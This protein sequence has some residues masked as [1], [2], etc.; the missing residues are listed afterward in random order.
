MIIC[1]FNQACLYFYANTHGNPH[2]K[3]VWN[4]YVE[5]LSGFCSIQLIQEK[6]IDF[7]FKVLQALVGTRLCVLDL[8]E[9]QLCHLNY[10]TMNSLEQVCYKE[11]S[12]N[13]AKY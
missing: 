3:R 13:G 6:N 2:S 4:L 12:H 10:T 8:F 11:R 5:K 1:I 7:T 9:V